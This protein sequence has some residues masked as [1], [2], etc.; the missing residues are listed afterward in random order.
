MWGNM[1]GGPSFDMRIAVLRQLRLPMMLSLACYVVA[2]GAI[3]GCAGVSGSTSGNGDAPLSGPAVPSGVMAAAGNAQVSLTWNV[4]TGAT[5][6][7]LKRGT[8][9]GGHYTQIAA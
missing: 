1:W 8:V 9:S 3:A 6:Y 2:V 7:H 5:S 4:S